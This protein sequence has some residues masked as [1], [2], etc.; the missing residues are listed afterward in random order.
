[1]DS[2]S[3]PMGIQV[4]V[5]SLFSAAGSV[6]QAGVPDLRS[7]LVISLLQHVHVVYVLAGVQGMVSG[8]RH[9]H[10]RAR[11]CGVCGIDFG[12]R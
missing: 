9:T 12:F 5:S 11:E 6:N 8:Y 7:P 2:F 4:N 3:P 10:A 1:M